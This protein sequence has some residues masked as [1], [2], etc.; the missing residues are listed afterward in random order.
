M[1]R[2]SEK[3]QK[4]AVYYVCNLYQ[5]VRFM[6]LQSGAS[7]V[8]IVVTF[9][10]NNVPK[11]CSLCPKVCCWLY[12]V[13]LGCGSGWFVGP[14]FPLCDGL[15]W[16]GSVVWLTKLDPRTTPVLITGESPTPDNA[17]A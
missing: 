8:S 13:R 3:F 16:V 10:C 4:L 7:L 14:K 6:N 9:M 2:G 12:G 1:G 11:L 17:S 5:T 15:G